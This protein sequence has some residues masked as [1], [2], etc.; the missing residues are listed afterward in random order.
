MKQLLKKSI[1]LIMSLTLVFTMVGSSV[2]AEPV[3]DNKN[4]PF[5]IQTVQ[6][7]ESKVII[8]AEYENDEAYLTLDK[9][10]E[11]IT[12]K[13]IEYGDSSVA[14]F[15]RG[16][17][18]PNSKNIV[19]NYNLEINKLVQAENEFLLAATLVNQATGEQIIIDDSRV[20]AQ[21]PQILGKLA[22]VLGRSVDHLL[23][24]GAVTA[25]GVIAAEIQSSLKNKK[26]EYYEASIENSPFGRTVIIGNPISVATAKNRVGKGEDVWA[27]NQILA[28]NL[29]KEWGVPV[30]P[31]AHG[32]KEQYLIHYFDHYHPRGTLVRAPE[33]NHGKSHIFFSF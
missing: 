24:I 7:D 33:G 9:S 20:E 27:K 14:G 28:F 29:A 13:T 23:K 4:D 12:F 10:T 26:P 19:N 22:E 8:K 16:L 21:F 17:I 25:T 11:N 3:S 18:D 2:F 1:S 6:N 30:G 5:N 15:L 31:Q 32:D